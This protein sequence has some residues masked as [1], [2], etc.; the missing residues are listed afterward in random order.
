MKIGPETFKNNFFSDIVEKKS[1]LDRREGPEDR[2]SRP[3]ESPK[4][5][6]NGMSGN[7]KKKIGPDRKRVRPL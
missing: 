3:K 4:E 7:V 5:G 1:G 2:A 6:L